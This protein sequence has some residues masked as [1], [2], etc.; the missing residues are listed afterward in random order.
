MRKD[1]LITVWCLSLCSR[2]MAGL[3]G[4]SLSTSLD[5]VHQIH[6]MVFTGTLKEMRKDDFAYR[7]I[8]M[9]L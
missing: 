5:S 3:P 7:L 4:D 6:E 2:A 1:I 9:V 8:S